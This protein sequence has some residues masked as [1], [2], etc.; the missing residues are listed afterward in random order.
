M[1]PGQ[2]IDI[3]LGQNL[4]AQ[5]VIMTSLPIFTIFKVSTKTNL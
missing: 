1:K 2:L 5:N 4:M 3:I